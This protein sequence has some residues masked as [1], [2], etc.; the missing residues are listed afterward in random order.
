MSDLALGLEFE[1]WL[2]N[3]LPYGYHK[4]PQKYAIDLIAAGMPSIEA[5]RECCHRAARTADHKLVNLTVQLFTKKQHGSRE[6]NGPWK[7]VA[8][9]KSALYVVG[10]KIS[11]GFRII[12][13]GLALELAQE[14]ESYMPGGTDH[15]PQNL[16][17]DKYSQKIVALVPLERL[18][19]IN[20]GLD[21]VYEYLD[22]RNF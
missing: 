17:V 8:Q 15:V 13:A 4:N 11:S 20:R 2:A 12:F 6:R 14:C 10:E 22:G 1:E 9:D 16:L 19:K 3:I 7:A 18:E 21:W 5:K